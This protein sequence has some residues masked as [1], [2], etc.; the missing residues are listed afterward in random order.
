MGQALGRWQQVLMEALAAHTVVGVRAVV[1]SHLSREPTRAE[2]PT[3]DAAIKLNR[4]WVGIDITYSAI[5]LIEKRLRHR[6][7]DEVTN[8][9][10]RPEPWR[11]LAD[12][13]LT[14]NVGHCQ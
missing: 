3:I 9:E 5:D 4:K 14:S 12:R 13:H 10:I 7:G 1:V 2:V 6:S 8:R 11:C